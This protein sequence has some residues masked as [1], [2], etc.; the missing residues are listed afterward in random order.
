MLTLP[1]P[2]VFSRPRLNNSSLSNLSNV[3]GRSYRDA[4]A[5]YG[6]DKPDLRV[7]L[8][9]ADV[10]DL[11]RDSMFRAFS[12]KHVLALSVPDCRGQPRS[13]FDNMQ[14]YAKSCG[15]PGLAWLRIGDDNEISGPIAKFMDSDQR[16]RLLA[17]TKAEP[18]AALFFGAAGDI[19]DARSI[20]SQVRVEAGK[21][22]GNFDDRSFRFCWIVRFSDV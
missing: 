11:F 7:P 15:S 9:L 13:F 1:R 16:Q 17:E 20:M 10:S 22:T 19:D 5:Q 14:E 4:L 8:Q 2:P 18:G 21:R 12:G 3:S 6:T